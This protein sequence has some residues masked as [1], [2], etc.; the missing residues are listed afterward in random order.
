MTVV[1]LTGGIAAGK[2][3]V[4]DVF[5]AEGLN[6]VDADELAREAVAPGTPALSALVDRFG[7]GVLREDGSLNRDGLAA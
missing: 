5:R 1:A 4:T 2:T 3:T 6:V 7:P